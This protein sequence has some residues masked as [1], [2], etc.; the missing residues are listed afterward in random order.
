MKKYKTPTLFALCLLPFAAVAGIFVSL[1]Q[2]DAYPGE[3]LAELIAQ[4]GSAEALVTVGTMQTIVYTLICGFFG[5][6][7]ADRVGLWKPIRFEKRSLGTTLL[8]SVIGGVAFSLDYWVF[9]GVID[10][11]RPA[12]AAGLTVN[13]VAAA[14]VYG[15]IVEEV[16]IRLF[17]MSLVAFIL[18]N[19]FRKN[20]HR[21][22]VPAGVPIAANILSALAFAAGHL[23]ATLALFGALTPLILF[24]CFLF[25]GGFGLVLGW[26]YRKYGIVYAMLGHLSLHIVSKAIWLALV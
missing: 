23:P 9:G 21:E 16:M 7:L 2:L 17:F 24:R 10:G 15:G 14:I 11:V 3:P 26:L 12:I 18:V 22:S 20:R 1:Y 25:N 5:C 19:V 6:V 4:V 13:G 8:L